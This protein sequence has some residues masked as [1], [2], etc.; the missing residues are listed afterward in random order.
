MTPFCYVLSED[1]LQAR[2]KCR[3]AEVTSNL[4][5]EAENEVVEGRFKQKRK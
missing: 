2:K 3:L 4:D 5:T 1:Y